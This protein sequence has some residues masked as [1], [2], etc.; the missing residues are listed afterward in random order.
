M[1]PTGSKKHKR[2]APYQRRK[3][4]MRRKYWSIAAL[5]L[6]LALAGC[7]TSHAA[8]PSET[9]LSISPTV[10]L[11][12]PTQTLT[13]SPTATRGVTTVPNMAARA[14]QDTPTASPTPTPTATAT[15]TP[16]PTNTPSPTPEPTA[17]A[18]PTPTNT[19]TPTTTPGP[20]VPFQAYAWM[21][22]YY[23]APGSVVTVYGR[24]LRYGRPI[25]GAN[26]GATIRFTN[27]QAYCSAYTNIDG[28]AACSVNIGA[29]LQGYWAFVDVVFTFA[30]QEIYAKTG[31]L[32]DP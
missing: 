14:F 31:F 18:T 25:D 22:N 2:F 23:P 6:L 1:Q 3:S 13:L 27:G 10:G 8:G 24:L 29:R 28:R 26:M 12:S 9:D 17:T 15:P 32:V 16:T 5:P 30:D 21:D 20:R 4:F 11:P 7:L 19:P